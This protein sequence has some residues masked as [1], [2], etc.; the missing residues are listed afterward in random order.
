VS[1][2]QICLRDQR[3]RGVAKQ[4]VTQADPEARVELPQGRVDQAD[5][6][7]VAPLQIVED[8]EQRL[9]R[10]CRAYEGEPAPREALDQATSRGAADRITEAE[11]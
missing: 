11:Q 6:E 9:A 4:R 10:G 8:D 2:A 5:A 3:V 7:R 1:S